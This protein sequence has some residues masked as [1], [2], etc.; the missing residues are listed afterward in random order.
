MDDVHV[1][2][3]GIELMPMHITQNQWGAGRRWMVLIFELT[4]FLVYRKGHLQRVMCTVLEADVLLC[5]M[6]LRRL[7][8]VRAVLSA[9]D[10]RCDAIAEPWYDDTLSGIQYC[11]SASA[12]GPGGVYVLLD[13]DRD[14]D[15]VRMPHTIDL[16]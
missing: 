4:P 6:E 3:Y 13:L 8:T 1:W 10:D 12:T 9:L 14:V 5:F 7:G 2:A 16:L 11:T 15:T